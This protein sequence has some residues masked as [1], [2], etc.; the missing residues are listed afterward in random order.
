V[1]DVRRI[2]ILDPAMVEVLRGKTPA[3]RV[4]MVFDANRTMRLMLSAHL[5]WQHPDWSEA[6][7]GEEIARRMSRG[8]G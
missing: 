2:E 6:Q 8:S 1:I 4:A 3:E 5:H 7:V